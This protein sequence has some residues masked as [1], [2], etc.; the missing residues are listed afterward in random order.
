M[1]AKLTTLAWGKPVSGLFYMNDGVVEELKAYTGG[2]SM[3]SD[4]AGSSLINFYSEKSVLMLPEEERPQ[5][6]A[7]V[8]IDP[9]LKHALLLCIPGSSEKYKIIVL[10]FSL[11]AFPPKSF[12]VFNFSQHRV[13]F[14]LGDK[15]D[16]HT[17]EPNQ[18][19][20]I[21][22]DDLKETNQMVKV[23]LAHESDGEMRLVYRSSWAVGSEIRNTVFILP[24]TNGKGGIQLRKFVERGLRPSGG[25]N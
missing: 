24:K 17:V 20:I 12:R 23:Q 8:Q 15:P 7:T 21:R 14:A 9:S 11:D 4:Y 10:D 2:F 1:Q 22:Q 5:P 13:V 25:V 6:V 18:T 16:I 19:S 3:P